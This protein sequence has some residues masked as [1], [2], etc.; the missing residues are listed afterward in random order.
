MLNTH[1]IRGTLI[2]ITFKAESQN[3]LDPVLAKP[4]RVLV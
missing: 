1:T 3:Y 4:D 2:N